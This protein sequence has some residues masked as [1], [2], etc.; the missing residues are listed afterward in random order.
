MARHW[1]YLGRPCGPNPGLPAPALLA[2]P[3]W[4]TR[5][6]P[7]GP[8]WPRPPARPGLPLGRPCGLGPPW[9]GRT[10]LPCPPACTRPGLA[11][12]VALPACPALPA[13]GPC[14][15]R[16]CG[17]PPAGQLVGLLPAY[18]G[19]EPCGLPASCTPGPAWADLVWPGGPPPRLGPCTRPCLGQTCGPPACPAP[20]LG[21][22]RPCGRARLPWQP[23]L[24]ALPGT[25]PA[26][27][28]LWPARLA[29]QPGCLDDLVA[30]PPA[31]HQACLG[32]TLWPCRAWPPAPGL[33][34]G[35]TLWPARP[36][37]APGCW[38][39]EPFGPLTC[40]APG[41]W[42]AALPAAL[43]PLPGA[44]LVGLP[45]ACLH[46]PCLE[47]PFWPGPPPASATRPAGPDLCGLPACL[48]KPACCRPFWVPACPLQPGPA[49]EP[50]WPPHQPAPGLLADRGCS[51]PPA[52]TRTCLACTTFWPC[53]P[54][55]TRPA[56]TL[57]PGRLPAP[58]PALDDLV[59]CPWPAP[60]LLGRTFWGYL[61]H[62][63][64]WHLVVARP[65]C[66]PAGRALPDHQDPAGDP[67]R[68]PG[69]VALPGL[70]TPGPRACLAD[71]VA[72][73]PPAQAPCLAD[74]LWPARLPATRLQDLLGPPACQATGLLG[75][76]WW[77][78]RLLPPPA[79]RGLGPRPLWPCL[80]A[81]RPLWPCLGWPG[82][83]PLP[84]GPALAGPPVLLACLVDLVG[85]P[86][87]RHQ[88]CGANLVACPPACTRPAWADL[89]APPP[90][91]TRPPG[92]TLWPGPPPCLALHQA[93]WQNLVACPPKPASCTRPAWARGLGPPP[94]CLAPGRLGRTLCGLPAPRPA[95]NR[96]G[97]TLWPG[98]PACTRPAG[99]ILWMPALPAPGLMG[100]TLWPCPA[101]LHQPLV[102]QDL[103]GLPAC[104]HQLFGRPCGHARCLAQG[105]LWGPKKDP[106]V[107]C[108]ACL[109]HRLADL[110]AFPPACTSLW[111]DLV[112][113]GL[114]L[115]QA[116]GGRPCGPAPP[117]CTWLLPEPCGL[118]PTCN[119]PGRQTLWPA[120]C[121]APGLAG[122]PL[123]VRLPGTR[124]AWAD[125]CGPCPP[126]LTTGWAD[127]GGLPALPPTRP[128]LG[129]DFV[130][131]PV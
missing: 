105:L 60:G 101:C 122:R 85:P 18:L 118:P 83:R 3:C 64:R 10:L 75:R 35:Q 46:R 98:P 120:R 38:A 68:G 84:A 28:T 40:P 44:D 39:Q 36:A 1:A 104:L 16:P 53:P 106:L 78:A 29:W 30:C 70:P 77:P 5:L 26:G 82:A 8:A 52:C 12:L 97:R 47:G 72:C 31:R 126:G 114:A 103:V 65:A 91:R 117:A 42:A 131:L 89:V 100:Q 125:P 33:V 79:T 49:G 43:A 59:A 94:A 34:P 74:T 110:V 9:L 27:Q 119:R 90:G 73:P 25:R 11:D 45:P 67:G 24:P 128:A 86:H 20:V 111:A 58:R 81:P 54:A 124:P 32:R 41:L 55:G 56:G 57:W 19:T 62:Q 95:C 112:G 96:A 99:Q 115:H 130:A 80:P 7:H 76:P 71:L 2:R 21:L 13:P 15:G 63:P 6:A 109:N 61:P 48:G 107:A 88:A 92:Q 87:L 37:L 108:P 51:C 14:W 123:V 121:L 23:G 129:P 116:S 102:G 127:L 93:A 17:L 4:P 50:L 22:G 113:P 66:R 69:I